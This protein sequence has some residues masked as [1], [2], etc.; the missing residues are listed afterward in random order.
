MNDMKLHDKVLTHKYI[1]DITLSESISATNNGYLLEAVHTIKEWSDNNNMRLYETKTK[2]MLISFKKNAIE[3]QPLI[4][5][6]KAIERVT[7]FKILGVWLSDTLSWS[8]HVHHMTSRASPRLYY[9]RQLKR[10]GLT[11]EDL[12]VYYKTMIQPILEYAC[13]VWHAGLTSGESDLLEQTQKRALKINYQ[14]LRLSAGIELSIHHSCHVA[15]DHIRSNN[16][17]NSD[18]NAISFTV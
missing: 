1:D 11:R 12:L 7:H 13:P 4:I 14:D 15:L 16:D 9:I 2:E 5:D 3:T 18:V 10:S 8:Y 17:K 6:K